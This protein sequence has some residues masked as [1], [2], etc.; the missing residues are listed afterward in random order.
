[1]VCQS[2]GCKVVSSTEKALNLLTVSS[3][4]QRNVRTS[5][6][7]S[8]HRQF[9]ANL[10]Q[11]TLMQGL[12]PSPCLAEELFNY[13]HSIFLLLDLR[14]QCQCMTSPQTV[15]K[16]TAEEVDESTL[17]VATLHKTNPEGISKIF[18]DVQWPSKM[19]T[20]KKHDL[21]KEKCRERSFSGSGMYSCTC[22]RS[23]PTAQLAKAAKAF[24]VH[25]KN[26]LGTARQTPPAFP[27]L[28]FSALSLMVPASSP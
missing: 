6:R 23:R 22:I 4:G 13:N 5:A 11:G 25:G 10:G 3:K 28:R 9:V 18:N 27:H 16:V 20:G 14:V 19:S 24:R 26:L 15:S 21:A 2:S 1:M 8:H 17:F 7:L 12:F